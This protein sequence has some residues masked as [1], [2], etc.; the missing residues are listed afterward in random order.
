MLNRLLSLCLLAAAL[1]GCVTVP[2]PL[3]PQQ[4]EA[5]H[6]TTVTVEVDP[7]ATLWWGDGDRAYARSKGLPE[8]DSEEL[9]KTPEARAFIAKAASDK[10][11]VALERQLRPVLAGQR[12]VK[13]VV[14][15]RNLRLTSVIQR[16]L[17]GGPHEMTADVTIVD[18]KTGSQILSH[19]GL[20]AIARA[21]EGIGGTLIDAAFLAAPIDRLTG[22]FAEDFRN[23]LLPQQQPQ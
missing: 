21:G 11:A 19:P 2:N 4:V 9:S 17:V 16:I 22:N 5:L 15:L 23:W 10:I 7:A 6:L 13:I 20:R 12:P 8:Q 18:A 3:A 14:T 1:S